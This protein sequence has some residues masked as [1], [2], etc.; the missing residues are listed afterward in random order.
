M[1]IYT[2]KGDKGKTFLYGGDETWKS[3]IRIEAYGSVDELN[4]FLG[5]V[6][7]KIKEERYKKLII[8]VQRDLYVI[9]GLLSEG[10]IQTTELKKHTK[11]FEQEI[12]NIES[13]LPKLNT[14][15]L[16]LGS[17]ISSWF[18]ILRSICRRVERNIV[19]CFQDEQD[20]KRWK[21]EA[22][23]YFNRLSDLFFMLAR[24]YNKQKEIKV[25]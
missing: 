19:R 10:K 16:P 24:Y 6:G 20:I 4:S 11:L 7:E 9:M 22:L 14:F 13:Q 21:L 8:K 1:A 17:E 12:N 23:S 25:S 5:L 2:K 18:H 3:D 15:I